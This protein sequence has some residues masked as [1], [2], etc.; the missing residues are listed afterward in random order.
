MGDTS[1]VGQGDRSPCP[2][3]PPSSVHAVVGV[4]RGCDVSYPG[5]RTQATAGVTGGHVVD[6]CA[7]D[8]V[9]ITAAIIR[10]R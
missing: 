5:R 1:G 2:R 7:I 9:G 3:P 8:L 10:R 4:E 6:V